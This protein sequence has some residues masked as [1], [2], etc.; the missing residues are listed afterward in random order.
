MS[1]PRPPAPN[2]VV[3]GSANVD[4]VMTC[5]RLPAPGRTELAPSYD[6]LPGGKGANQAHAARRV[7]TALA[8]LEAA[9]DARQQQR[10]QQQQQHPAPPSRV[11]FVGAVGEDA[12][13]TILTDAFADVGVGVAHLERVADAPTACAAVIVERDAGENQI[14]VGGGANLR[15]RAE[16]LRDAAFADDH[17]GDRIH[18]PLVADGTVLLTQMEVP[19]EETAAAIRLARTRGAFV[20]HNAAPG[21]FVPPETLRQLDAL[22]VNE[23]ELREVF[24]RE[25]AE[26]GAGVGAS[27]KRF[28][29]AED[30]ED[31]DAAS[32]A[33]AMATRLSRW[34]GAIVIVTLGA[35][36][37]VCCLAATEETRPA[38]AHLPPFSMRV[39]A[40]PLR[41]AGGAATDTTGAGDAFAGAFAASV[42][43]GGS[44]G[45]ALREA[46]ACGAATCEAYGARSGALE[47]AV[48]TRRGAEVRIAYRGG[49]GF[50]GEELASDAL[51]SVIAFAEGKDLL[52]TFKDSRIRGTRE[53]AEEGR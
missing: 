14:C 47:E 1:S 48:R 18:R 42:A 51:D 29:P 10:Q 4:L 12:F 20:A 5:D 26:S 49:F 30:D 50:H 24:E 22:V 27:G 9:S 37:A 33:R 11:D 2:V 15:A 32:S 53:G 19:L 43:R 34:T 3:F 7:A 21:G 41:G 38:F 13:A 46:S 35:K 45:D 39:S 36:G 25:R 52:A 6:L 44:L 40:A 28:T 16:S 31:D 8:A 23:H 17:D